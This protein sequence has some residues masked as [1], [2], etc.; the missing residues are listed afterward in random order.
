MELK[1]ACRLTDCFDVVDIVE[2]ENKGDDAK[3]LWMM[4]PSNCSEI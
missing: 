1:L 2:L 4:Y 3:D